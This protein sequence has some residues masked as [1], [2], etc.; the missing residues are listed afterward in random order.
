MLF[1]AGSDAALAGIEVELHSCV[2]SLRTAE[3]G[4]TVEG[5]TAGV[6]EHGHGDQ[7]RG[8]RSQPCSIIVSRMSLCWR[9]SFTTRSF[10][11]GHPFSE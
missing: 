1:A 11:I 3:H 10:T 4:A 2:A 8:A 7:S 6:F 9:T 5:V